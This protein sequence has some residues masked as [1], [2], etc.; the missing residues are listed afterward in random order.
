MKRLLRTIAF[1]RSFFTAFWPGNLAQVILFVT[2]QCNAECPFCFN[3]RL[4][5]NKN[6]YK[7]RELLKF[8]EYEIIAKKIK[9]VFQVVLG[10]GEP[11]LREDIGKITKAFYTYAKARLISIPTNG[12]MD[13]RI[14]NQIG[15]IVKECPLATVNLI[16]SLDAYGAVHDRMRG[17]QGCFEK[18][19]NLCRRIITL[20][21]Q[22]KN[23]NLVINTV[24]L[25]DNYDTIIVLSKYL[26]ETLGEANYYHNFQIDQR[27]NSGEHR[28]DDKY[29]KSFFK[30]CLSVR[31]KSLCRG[32]GLKGVIDQ[33]Y[34]F[35]INKIIGE[36]LSSGK[37][38]YRCMA[39]KKLSVIMPEGLV[40]M[41]EPFIF[42]KKYNE[43]KK[44]NIRNYN[45][46]Y[47]LLQKE[48]EFKK[49]QEFAGEMKCLPCVWSCGAI[50]S[51][52]YGI[53]NWKL[54]L[55]QITRNINN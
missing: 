19:V 43:V 37:M 26:I 17:Y 44:F 10:G 41:C 52:I 36:Q 35:L 11:F 54:L 42:E 39:G 20:K 28:K 31:K 27:L 30:L 13:E 48:P 33:Y 25:A 6:E 47:K 18:A 15:W 55:Q 22:C 51:M 40:S 16:V 49:V 34:V 2:D 5:R 1:A 9:P 24:L 8:P 29:I 45:Y 3:T 23:I 12:I 38:I 21:K 46:D 4:S 50:T 32:R 14:E 53:R 7:H